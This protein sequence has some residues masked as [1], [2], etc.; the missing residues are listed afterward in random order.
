MYSQQVLNNNI[1]QYCNN[2][3]HKTAATT[4]PINNYDIDTISTTTLQHLLQQQQL[5]DQNEFTPV[6][7][8]TTKS[9]KP[10]FII[11]KKQTHTELVQ[12]LHATYYSPV[13]S[14]WI[15][16]IK[17]N[18]FALWPGLT[19]ELVEKY[20]PLTLV[21]VQGHIHC[22]KQHLQSTKKPIIQLPTVAEATIDSFPA[23]PVPNNK[24]NKVCY[25]LIDKTKFLTAYQDLTGRFPVQSD[26]G[27]EY[28]LVSYHYST[29]YIHGIPVCNRTAN[30]LT[31][32]WE[33]L[34][35]ISQKQEQHQ[36]FGLWI[37]EFPKNS[38]TLLKE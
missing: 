13:K 26:Q 29:N 15:K 30:S 11:R 12:Y 7:I 5:C 36:M 19:A 17:N 14:T 3:K 25:I 33:T 24:V 28:I 1:S 16:A 2:I 38:L 35:S 8:T 20:L 32:A 37:T 18:S 9:N 31:A 34:H 27:N 4:T 6:N 22:E 10:N 23:S 21:T